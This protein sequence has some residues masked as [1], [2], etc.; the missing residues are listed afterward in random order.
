MNILSIQIPNTS[1]KSYQDDGVIAYDDAVSQE[2]RN[3]IREHYNSWHYDVPYKSVYE[4]GNKLTVTQL[5]SML[6]DL[7]KYHGVQKID[8]TNIYRGQTLVEKPYY[9]YDIKNKG[10]KTVI[11]LVDYGAT[12]K[13]EVEK[14]GMDY[15]VYNIYEN[16]WNKID[17]D[18]EDIKK[19]VDFIKVMQ[20]DNIYVGCQHGANDTD[21]A[22]II[23]DFFNPKLAGKVKTTIPASDADFPIKLNMIYEAFTNAQ[24][25][26]LGWTKEFEQKLLKKLISI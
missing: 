13:Q 9:L 22:F 20:K 11:D 7:E 4:K 26:S 8:G 25:K 19:I 15:Y 12:Y 24:K 14:A 17:F 3:Y 1:F 5:Q 10:V 23:N 2:R 21:I 18:K 6:C 16:W